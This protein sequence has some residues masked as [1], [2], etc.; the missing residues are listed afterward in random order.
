M[1]EE[2]GNLI[3]FI[4]TEYTEFNEKWQ[5]SI[6]YTKVNLK[7]NE[8]RDLQKN[9]KIME[10]IINYR[11][12]INR[13]NV[14][15]SIDFQKFNSQK[16]QISIRVKALNSIEQKIKYFMEK[17]EVGKVQINKCFNDLFGIRMVCTEELTYEQILEYINDNYKNLK[18]ID[19]TKKNEEYFATHIYFKKDNFNFQWELQIWNKS[20]E[21]DNKNA[22]EKYKQGYI[23]W[24]KDNKGEDK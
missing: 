11:E 22:H 16:A 2:L 5:N 14:Q 9:E 6:Y 13:N 3:N 23:K 1:L 24:E 19:S 18:C 17:E 21:V 15:L 7:K 12:F 20:N 4:Q 10:A 8:I